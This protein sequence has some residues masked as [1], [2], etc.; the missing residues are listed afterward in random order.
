MYAEWFEIH[1]LHLSQL[2]EHLQDAPQQS[3]PHPGQV[4]QVS[5]VSETIECHCQIHFQ[6]NAK[7]Q[8]NK[9]KLTRHDEL[10]V[11]FQESETVKSKVRC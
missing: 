6:N 4:W 2:Q 11:F 3:S 9:V 5:Q 7:D 10:K 1:F 8:N